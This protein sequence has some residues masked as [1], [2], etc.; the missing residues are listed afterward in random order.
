[1]SSQSISLFVFDLDGTLV[2]S[3][4]LLFEAVDQ[5][6]KRYHFR[7]PDHLLRA[8]SCLLGHP[9]RARA[10]Q[11]FTDLDFGRALSFDDFVKELKGECLSH[12]V[13][14]GMRLMPGARDLVRQLTQAGHRLAIA[15]G[16]DRQT[17]LATSRRF[18]DFF[19]AFSFAIS[20]EPTMRPK[21]APDIYHQVIR[22]YKTLFND[23]LDPRQVLVFE[24]TLVGVRAARAA[25]M[26]VVHVIDRRL[27]D[28]DEGAESEA[29]HV[30]FSLEDFD[31]KRLSEQ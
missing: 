27:N 5:L 7:P 18:G 20:I 26:R 16:N 8:K 4:S 22:E 14:H 3:E 2:D 11:L 9:F 31:W 13:K 1:M 30:V 21:P 23:D 10:Q 12:V 24:D 28:V 25:G 15:T 19:S 6:I 29:D 17:F